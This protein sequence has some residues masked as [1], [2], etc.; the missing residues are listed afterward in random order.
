MTCANGSRRTYGDLSPGDSFVS[1]CG[2]FCCSYPVKLL[3]IF[4]KLAFIR[5]FTENGNNVIFDIRVITK[6]VLNFKVELA[7]H[8]TDNSDNKCYF[9]EYSKIS[10]YEA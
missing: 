6:Y 9:L 4:D 8:N 5:D 1:P 3:F 7:F 10:S 2:Y